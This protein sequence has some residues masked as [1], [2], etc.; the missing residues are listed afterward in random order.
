MV[1]M[2]SRRATYK[3]AFSSDTHNFSS[4]LFPALICTHLYNL[5]YGSVQMGRE[6]SWQ[7]G[8]SWSEVLLS[9]LISFD[10]STATRRRWKTQAELLKTFFS[11]FSLVWMNQKV[12]IEPGMVFIWDKYNR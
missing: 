7:G 3:S 6:F 5:F 8:P 10:Q 1:S 12:R 11:P 2:Q 9:E 4:A